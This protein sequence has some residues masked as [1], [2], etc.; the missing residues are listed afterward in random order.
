MVSES[1]S[2][3]MWIQL[4]THEQLPPSSEKAVLLQRRGLSQFSMHKLFQHKKKR[5]G[6][7]SLI[8]IYH[9]RHILK[10]IATCRICGW[11]GDSARF[12]RFLIYSS[13]WR[14]I[15]KSNLDPKFVIKRKY[16]FLELCDITL[17][18]LNGSMSQLFG[19]TLHHTHN[20]TSWQHALCYISQLQKN[21]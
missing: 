20:K 17:C 7:L 15:H 13:S 5:W 14:K 3:L 19:L 1:L 8:I 12:L 9:L 21:I 11:A 2:S 6:W 18:N 4:V 16:Y 10:I